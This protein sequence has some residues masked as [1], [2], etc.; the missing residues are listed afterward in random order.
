M[1]KSPLTVVKERFKTKQA[2]IDAVK[3][4][5]T[6]E[7]W[8]GARLNE[9]KGLPRVSNAKLLHL[10]DVLAQVKKEHGSRAKLIDAIVAAEKR[11]KDKDYRAG[12]EQKPTPALFEQLRAAKKRS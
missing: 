6:D 3:A 1:Q 11:A 7:L 9:G 4:L 5:A 8:N 10:H 12:L 2:L